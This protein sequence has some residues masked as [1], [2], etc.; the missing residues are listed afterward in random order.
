MSTAHPNELTTEID[1]NHLADFAHAEY[2][3]CPHAEYVTGTR[4]QFFDY[5]MD[6]QIGI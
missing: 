6:K 4:V 2:A 3:V 1:F 5:P